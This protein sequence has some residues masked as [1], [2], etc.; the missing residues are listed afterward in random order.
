M[1]VGGML[2]ACYNVLYG[3]RELQAVAVRTVIFVSILWRARDI[4]FLYKVQCRH[5]FNQNF[6]T[7]YRPS[8]KINSQKKRIMANATTTE[9]I[10]NFDNDEFMYASLA[11]GRS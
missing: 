6:I 7:T 8:S 4:S 10:A 5:T 3:T 2:F 9:H 1:E 11:V